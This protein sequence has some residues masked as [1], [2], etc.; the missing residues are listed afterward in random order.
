[1]EPLHLHGEM[2]R[3]SVLSPRQIRHEISSTNDIEE[4]KR[5]AFLSLYIV[6][7]FLQMKHYTPVLPNPLA[8]RSD[9]A[10]SNESTSTT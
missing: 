6:F 1:M 3:P 10:S 4:R 5:L 9:T 2:N 8:P 7:H